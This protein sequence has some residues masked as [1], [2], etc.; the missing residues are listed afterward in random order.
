LT[1]YDHGK[2]VTLPTEIGIPGGEVHPTCYYWIHVHAATPHIIHVESPIK[3]AFTLG[4]F[5]DIWEAT[6]STAQPG[7]D[8]FIKTLRAAAARRQ[9]KVF[10]EKQRRTGSYRSVP[11]LPDLGITIEIGKPTRPPKPYAS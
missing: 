11:L 1:L 4:N 9:V 2:Q 3:K 10:V 5:F 8:S 6:N 7:G